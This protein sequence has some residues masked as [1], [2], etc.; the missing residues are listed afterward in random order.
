MAS[1]DDFYD[2]R[3]TIGHRQF[4]HE[5]NGMDMA[6]D[7]TTILIHTHFGLWRCVFILLSMSS[8]L[9]LLQSH[10]IFMTAQTVNCACEYKCVYAYVQFLQTQFSPI[11]ILPEPAHVLL[12]VKAIF[13]IS[14]C[15]HHTYTTTN[16]SILCS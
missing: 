12:F 15:G 3:L 6:N 11:S 4:Q 7:G 13:T 16:V 10:T 1:A 9:L 5:W 8:S 14:V 2:M